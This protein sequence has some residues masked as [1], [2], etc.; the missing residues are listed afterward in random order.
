MTWRFSQRSI[1]ARS[2]NRDTEFIVRF[3][4]RA[5]LRF[6][7]RREAR[8]LLSLP[9]GFCLGLQAA[10]LSLP[11]ELPH[12]AHDEQCGRNCDNEPEDY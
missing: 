11:L 4:L 9:L 3:L 1:L 8:C 10:C 12:C 5:L 6:C 2:S 7:F